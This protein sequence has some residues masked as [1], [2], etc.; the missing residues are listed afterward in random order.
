[1]VE[2]DDWGK[3]A[4]QAAVFTEDKVRRWSAQNASVVGKV[5]YATAMGDAGELRLGALKGSGK[6]GGASARGS[7][8]LQ[9]TSTGITFR[10]A[11]TFASLR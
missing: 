6:A 8:K 4:T 11:P 5:Q 10:A 1:L 2:S 3:V 9:A 7:R